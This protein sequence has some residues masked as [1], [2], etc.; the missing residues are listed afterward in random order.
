M[1]LSLMQMFVKEF[2]DRKTGMLQWVKSEKPVQGYKVPID[3]TSARSETDPLVVSYA[4]RSVFMAIASDPSVRIFLKPVS[5]ASDHNAFPMNLRDSFALDY[6]VP[7]C[8]IHWDAQ[9]GKTL[10]L[11]FFADGE[12][13]SGSQLSVS[14]GGVSINEGT[15]ISLAAP[16]TLTAAAAAIIAPV[17]LTRKVATIE[18]KTG[19]S[20]FV[21]DATVTNA[22]ATEGIIVPPGGIIKWKNTGALYGYSVAGGKVSRAEEV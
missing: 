10:E 21:G 9:P 3:L 17:L 8:F 13:R 5:K 19:A 20:L 15:S 7:E 18:N 4:F 14:S 22:G 11:M 2:I 6:Q 1:S 12:F 16:V